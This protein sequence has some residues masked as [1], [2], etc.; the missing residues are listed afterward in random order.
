VLE[1]VLHVIGEASVAAAVQGHLLVVVEHLEVLEGVQATKDKVR[2]MHLF[3]LKDRK[4][5]GEPFTALAQCL[6]FHIVVQYLFHHLDRLLL[7]H[8]QRFEH[9]LVRADVHSRAN[10]II[11]LIPGKERCEEDLAVNSSDRDG[12]VEHNSVLPLLYLLYVLARDLDKGPAKEN[13]AGVELGVEA[14]PLVGDEQPSR[15]DDLVTQPAGKTLEETLVRQVTDF[16][17]QKLLVGVF[18]GR[19]SPLVPLHRL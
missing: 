18:L 7:L 6:F 4:Q 3:V 1:T 19:R 11:R 16:G 12:V 17:Q 2:T 13:G 9:A 5:L 10:E 8:L 14:Q 15:K